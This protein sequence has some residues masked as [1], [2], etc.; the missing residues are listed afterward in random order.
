MNEEG[1]ISVSVM[2]EE[3]VMDKKY[4]IMFLLRQCY[5]MGYSFPKYK[6]G[7]NKMG[8]SEWWCVN[9]WII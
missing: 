9:D 1:E 3:N 8:E 5:Y 6:R 2:W 7:R 4:S